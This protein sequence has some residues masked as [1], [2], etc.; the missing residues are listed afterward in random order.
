MPQ[1]F[2]TERPNVLV[3]ALLRGGVPV[4]REVARALGAPLD[5]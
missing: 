1:G 4:A 3:L 5:V 2:P